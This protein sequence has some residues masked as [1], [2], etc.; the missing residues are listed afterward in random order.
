[1][2]LA[3]DLRL[4]LRSR[5]CC[6]S[7]PWVPPFERKPTPHVHSC[8]EC[9]EDA[10]CGF[11]CTIEPDLELDNGM[12]RGAFCVCR[13]CLKRAGLPEDAFMTALPDHPEQHAP[14]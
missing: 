5:R 10:V 12:P 2:N 14:A 11:D 9:Y 7:K 8:P 3:D 1:M 13:P 4:F 6:A